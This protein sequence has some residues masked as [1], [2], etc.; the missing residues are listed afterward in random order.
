MGKLLR[1]GEMFA[2]SPTMKIILPYVHVIK[3][4]IVQIC[5]YISLLLKLASDQ[6]P[7]L[8]KWTREK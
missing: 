6:E 5:K 7:S 1:F 8:P 4:H 3:L 2:L